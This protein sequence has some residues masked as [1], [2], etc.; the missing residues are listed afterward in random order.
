MKQSALKRQKISNI[1]AKR[2]KEMRKKEGKENDWK[3]VSDV[4]VI[5]QQNILMLPLLEEVRAPLDI[6]LASCMMRPFGTQCR[7]E[8]AL[9]ALQTL[10]ALTDQCCTEDS[11][12]LQLRSSSSFP[13]PHCWSHQRCS[14]C[15]I[16]SFP[17]KLWGSLRALRFH[18]QV[19]LAPCSPYSRSMFLFVWNE[20]S[21]RKKKNQ[22]TTGIPI[23]I[24]P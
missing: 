23:T 18:P 10:F 14:H 1:W 24:V 7:A 3:K 6:P 5:L 22:I 15:R 17:A 21:D 13:F 4:A 9:P 2:P 20:I 8:I 16:R 12:I 19:R 11:K